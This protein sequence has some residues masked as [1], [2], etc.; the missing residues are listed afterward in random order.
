M[1]AVWQTMPSMV[2]CSAVLNELTY[3]TAWHSC[4]ETSCL[5]FP[6]L[7]LLVINWAV[8]TSHLSNSPSSESSEIHSLY[9]TQHL[10]SC[11]RPCLRFRLCRQHCRH[12][13]RSV[14]CAVLPPSSCSFLH[15]YPSFVFFRL[16]P[17]INLFFSI[18][19][20][21]FFPLSPS[22]LSISLSLRL[23]SC[24]LFPS[25]LVLRVTVYT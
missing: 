11:L 15:S 10:F 17:S 7:W 9:A 2:Q 23:P 25:P 6:S 8:N 20:F 19:I 18:F 13:S 3:D 5:H 16:Q 14:Q 22:L 4:H 1:S 24:Y 12:S 21:L